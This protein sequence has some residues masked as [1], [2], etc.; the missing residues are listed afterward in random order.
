MYDGTS[1]VVHNTSNGL[2]SN[3]IS[4]IFVDSRGAVWVGTNDGLNRYDGQ[5]WQTFTQT[6]GLPASEI[7]SINEDSQG[8]VW[9]LR[10][11]WDNV[12][13]H[14]A[15]YDGTAWSST[16]IGSLNGGGFYDSF[17]IDKNDVFWIKSVAELLRLGNIFWEE[18]T[19]W[20]SSL[21]VNQAA[22]STVDYKAEVGLL[23]SPGKYI[24]RGTLRS[25]TGQEIAAASYPFQVFVEDVCLNLG[26]EKRYYRKGEEAIISGEVVNG[27]DQDEAD[28]LLKIYRKFGNEPEELVFQDSFPLAAK[29]S[30]PWSLTQSE[31]RKGVVV[32]RGELLRQQTIAFSAESGYEV[33]APALE[34]EVDAPEVVGNDPFNLKVKLANRGK[35][36]GAMTIKILSL[37]FEQDV[38]LAPNEEKI[39]SIQARE[40]TTT[41]YVVEFSGDLESQV[42]KT[43]VYGYA[44]SIEFPAPLIYPK[45]VAMIPVTIR[46]TGNLD[47]SFEVNYELYAAANPVLLLT[48]LKR[49]YSL[50]AQNSF[51]DS[52]PFSLAP[53]EYVLKYGSA[54]SQGQVVIGV[55]DPGAGRL[56]L[57]EQDVYAQGLVIMPLTLLNEAPYAGDIDVVFQVLKGQ[58]EV[59]TASRS[60]YLGAGEVRSDSISFP[61]TVEGEYTLLVQ[62]AKVAPVPPVGFRVVQLERMEPSVAFGTPSGGALP[63]SVQLENTGCN[64]FQGFVEVR[65]DFYS[66]QQAVNVPAGQVQNF[67]MTLSLGGGTAGEHQVSVVLVSAAGKETILETR[68]VKIEAADIVV[69]QLPSD[70]SFT[71]GEQASLTFKLRNRGNLEGEA[72]LVLKVMDILNETRKFFVSSGAEE[73]VTFTFG[74][75]ADLVAQDYSAFYRLEGSGVKAAVEGDVRFSVLGIAVDVDAQLD[76]KSYRQGETARLTLTVTNR[77]QGP[78]E[79]FAR[80]GYLDYEGEQSFTL[81]TSTTLDFLIPLPRITEEKASYGIY[82]RDGRGVYLNDIYIYKKGEGAD[83]ELDQQVYQPGSAVLVMIT[84]PQAG[85]MRISAP[86][87][88][89]EFAVDGSTSRS[90]AL[91][92]DLQAGTYFLGWEFVPADGSGT[93]SSSEMFDVAGLKVVVT[94]ASLSKGKY[95][96][97]ETVA[98]AVVFESNQSVAATLKMWVVDPEG[99]DTEVASSPVTLSTGEHTVVQESLTFTTEF[100]GMHSVVYGLYGAN[101][102]LLVSGSEAFDCGGAVVL[103]VSTEKSEYP[104]ATEE[105]KTRVQLY[106]DGRAD[107]AFFINGEPVKTAMTELNGVTVEEV[108]IEPSLLKPG[109]LSLRVE[110]QR[111]GLTSRKETSFAYGSELP[112]LMFESLVSSRNILAYTIKAGLSNQGQTAA[113]TTTVSFYEG[114]PAQGGLLIAERPLAGLTAGES[115]QV[116]IPWSGQAKSGAKEIFAAV[117]QGQAVKELNEDNNT[118]SLSLDI[119]EIVHELRLDKIVFSAFED[120]NMVTLIAN[121]RETAVQG[122]WKLKIMSLASGA[123]VWESEGEVASIAPYGQLL[124]SHVFNWGAKPEG[125]YQ[126]IQTMI[127]GGTG[128]EDG[129]V[130]TVLKTEK[131]AATFTLDPAKINPNRDESVNVELDLQNRG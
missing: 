117:D 127:L 93:E 12:S 114:D 56:T 108:I 43:V 31:E 67:D 74:I 34:A 41:E 79:L 6:D 104:L 13:F 21:T 47:Q 16:Y 54:L 81:E 87:Y 30:R 63:L 118:V 88:E 94:E 92:P 19:V 73:E 85:L 68:T 37:G 57:Q 128:F 46:N 106:G 103:A 126:V 116:E 11:N 7:L 44:A 3:S 10:F 86:G 75:P 82:H 4:S 52:L 5:S 99:R 107:L 76:K 97:G 60:Y 96:P 71:A 78:V 62:G 124:M 45:G 8:A 9:I 112:D 51:L 35:I 65:S 100:A 17:A 123:V 101:D 129:A 90:F 72:E 36:D 89:E 50:P 49:V 115:A 58:E 39:F 91:P 48:N 113:G 95:A 119:P 23:S 29:G 80:V 66:S 131:I 70:Q 69:S 105:V 38:N 120:M 22:G 26:A 18:D 1:W 77:N 32:L 42:R 83:V 59:F 55:V 33:V 111:D 84:T 130:V 14:L 40:T 109:H 98:A 64:D 102:Q 122:Q 15:R 121:N 125:D 61:I 53:G 27:S 25:V 28:L 20:T 2:S 24:L 110:V